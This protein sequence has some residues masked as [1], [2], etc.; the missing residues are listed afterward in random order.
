MGPKRSSP[1]WPLPFAE[2]EE[3]GFSSEQLVY[4]ALE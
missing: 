2:P 4:Q 1:R 3:V